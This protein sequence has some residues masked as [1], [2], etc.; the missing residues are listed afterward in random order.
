MG[1]YKCLLFAVS[2]VCGF[3]WQCYL[4]AV[5]VWRLS[6]V[7]DASYPFIALTFW[8]PHE[9]L[10][11][12]GQPSKRPLNALCSCCFSGTGLQHCAGT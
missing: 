10:A 12:V 3:A 8:P 1:P 4:V 6:H 5:T 7:V 11:S 2:R 9:H